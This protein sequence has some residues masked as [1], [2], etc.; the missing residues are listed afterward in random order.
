M[1]HLYSFCLLA[2][3]IGNQIDVHQHGLSKLAGSAFMVS[4]TVKSQR[5]AQMMAWLTAIIWEFRF[6]PTKAIDGIVEIIQRQE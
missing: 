5:P 1:P 4:A 3:E 6:K 2:Q